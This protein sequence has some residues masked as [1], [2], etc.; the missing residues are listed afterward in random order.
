MRKNNQVALKKIQRSETAPLPISI[1]LTIIFF[2]TA[3]FFIYQ[4]YQLAKSHKVIIP[5]QEPIPTS[6]PTPAPP[7]SEKTINIGGYQVAFPIGWRSR[8][9]ETYPN[10]RYDR[11]PSNLNEPSCQGTH[12][13]QMSNENNTY[14]I[15][16]VIQSPLV[17]GGWAPRVDEE[18]SLGPAGYQAKFRFF[19]SGYYK[20]DA[21]HPEAGFARRLDED[22][23][24]ELWTAGGCLKK[25]LCVYFNPEER[26]S[27]SLPYA[28]NWQNAEEFK[29]FI[30][31]LKIEK[32]PST[33]TQ[34]VLE[35]H[36]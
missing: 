22:G 7:F 19:W 21:Y 26:Y 9:V 3:V 28:T 31:S 12:V 23:K 5:P 16:D 32:L 17:G 1:V 14:R 25:G 36:L 13:Q 2:A 29:K 6:T 11:C 35:E 18:I 10:D 4:Y 20:K 8:P 27:T 24:P 15:S 30:N 34:Q 33:S